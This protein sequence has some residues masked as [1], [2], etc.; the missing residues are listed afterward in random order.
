[1]F[2]NQPPWSISARTPIGRGV[3]RSIA[4]TTQQVLQIADVL[5]PAVDDE[6]AA[7][8]SAWSKYQS[9]R[10]RDAV[11]LYL[12]AVFEIVGRWKKQHRAKARSQ[13]AL[14][15]TTAL[16]ADRRDK[17]EPQL[18]MDMVLHYGEVVYGNV[19][20]ARRL[21]FTVIGPTVNEAS[22]IEALCAELGQHLL[23]SA[24]FATRCGH[25]T[26]SQGRFALRGC[27]GE[28]EV[29]ALA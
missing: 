14:A 26:T 25:A 2:V 3:N 12:T 6:L 13:Q 18:A 24:P 19:G 29:V 21:D 10:Q 27:P 7:A 16:N 4:P 15:A 5:E 8:R 28:T 20:A 1:M 23:L 22:R 11:Y 17:G 9:T